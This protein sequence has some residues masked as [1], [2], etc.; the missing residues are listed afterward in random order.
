M[1]I[2][3]ERIR[4]GINSESASQTHTP[5]PIAKNAIKMYNSIATSHPLL[6]SGTGLIKAFSIFSGAVR[7]ASMFANGFL[8]KASMRLAGTQLARVIVTAEPDGSSERTTLV[9]AVKSP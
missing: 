4:V 6:V 9:A 3:L 2:P 1:L 7:A 5:G 8:V